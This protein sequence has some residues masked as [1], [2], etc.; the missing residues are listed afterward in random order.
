MDEYIVNGIV[1][2]AADYKEN[3]ILITLF[4][5]ELGKIKAILKGAKQPKAK[6]KYAGQQF[7]FAEWVLVKRGEFFTVTSV[8]VT[9]AFFD[10]TTDYDK[11]LNAST[12]LEICGHIL[13]PAMISETLFV[14]LLKA[15]KYIVYE[16]IDANLVLSKFML[17][18]LTI[19]GYG[20]NFKACGV[21]DMPI[22][23]DVI[24]SASTNEFCCVSCSGGFGKNIT[25]KCY[26]LLKII[27]STP[28]ERLSTIKVKTEDI[29]ECVAVL[30]FD[31]SN[32]FS[33]KL[34]DIQ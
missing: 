33:I 6:L 16:N 12:L 2:S 25:K 31:V 22:A 3:D 13:K 28:F 27:D 24:L 14:A 4:T 26:G 34:K 30:K 7:C 29:K 8:S 23:G 18:T 5:A 11:F 15:L 32:V 9:D 19:S 20:L 21:C 10:I 17:E 1:L